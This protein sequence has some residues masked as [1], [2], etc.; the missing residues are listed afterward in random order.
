ML[1]A[2]RSVDLGAATLLAFAANA[3][4]DV[5]ALSPATFVRF[6]AELGAA[7]GVG[8]PSSLGEGHT[9]AAPHAAIVGGLAQRAPLVP[10]YELE[11][12]VA[13]G[14]ASSLDADAE[15]QRV[16]GFRG[17]MLSVEASVLF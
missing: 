16:V 13:G 8:S 1:G 15:G 3:S 5:V 10:G 14:Y 17:G 7:L 9:H 6:E 12:F 11:L 4:A 2:R